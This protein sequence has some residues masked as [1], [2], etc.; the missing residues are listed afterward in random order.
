MKPLVPRLN[1]IYTFSDFITALI[2]IFK[3]NIDVSPLYDLFKNDKI[4]FVNH[5]RTGIR[6]ALNSLNLHRGAYIGVQVY[7]C[8]TVFNA[9]YQAGYKPVFIDINKQFQIDTT[10]LKNK[11]S[12]IDALIV[13][14]LF[15][16][17]ANMAEIRKTTEGLPVIEDCA[18]AFL[19]KFKGKLMGTFGDIGVFS[20]GKAK[21]PSIGQGGFIIINT[22]KYIDFAESQLNTLK[23]NSI[24]KELK[25]IVN[26]F[27]MHVLHKPLIYGS[28]TSP[29]L[30]KLDTKKDISGKFT[31]KEKKIL[32]TNKYLFLR[33]MNVYQILKNKQQNNAKTLMNIYPS[34]NFDESL[35][36]NPDYDFNFFMLPLI[37][38]K[39]RNKIIH[40]FYKMNQE[41]GAHFHKSILWAKSF[42]YQEGE[43]K[44]AEKI[45]R[46]VLTFPTYYY[47]QFKTSEAIHEYLY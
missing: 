33:K 16:I 15:G 19:S 24:L 21:F 20:M 47:N 4:Y 28:F 7:N 30:K 41:I 25:S 38:E 37:V 34:F 29:I 27:I 26:N 40:E 5:A 35:Y 43:C 6:V 23:N 10:D 31:F 36:I 46:Q 2:G 14:H 17:P 1:Y 18:H 32:K 13:T 9:I 11:K 8:H 42:G 12:K 39:N 22:K 45:V 3:N 44:N